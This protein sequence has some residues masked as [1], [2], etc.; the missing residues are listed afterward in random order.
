MDQTL[1]EF[2]KQYYDSEVWWQTSWLGFQTLKT[3]T[4][5]WIYQ[6]LIVEVRPDLVIESGT[7][8]GGSALFLAG[9]C[10]LIGHG[11]VVSIDPVEY[12]DRPRHPRVTY[13]VGSSVDAAI[14][15][16]LR[17]MVPA[18]GQCLVILDSDHRKDHVRNELDIYSPLIGVGGYIIVEDTNV[19]GH[20]VLP[21]F[22]PGPMEA[23]DEF[24]ATNPD[25]QADRTREKFGL[26]FNPRGYLRRIS[27]STG[28]RRRDDAAAG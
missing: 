14:A 13:M 26:T 8:K 16:Q 20:P 19:N 10:E 12:E 28:G 15:E 24:L 21:D 5:L 4:D 3:P 17:N 1:V 27:R 6:E 11:R 22:G 23:V 2:N 7:Y 9:I 18:G 25:F